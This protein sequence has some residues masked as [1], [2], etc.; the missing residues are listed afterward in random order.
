MSGKSGAGSGNGYQQIMSAFAA[1]AKAAENL[2]FSPAP[3]GQRC[4]HPNPQHCPHPESETQNDFG[5]PLGEPMSI[6]EVA[7][8]FGC[9]EW[10]IRQRYLPLGLPHF[11]LS[12]A[13]KLLFFHNQ[14]VRWVLEIQRQK[15]GII[16]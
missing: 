15:G 2:V 10:T 6:R 8:V 11:R 13:G 12:P 14:I 3:L 7:K 4:P 16:R 9:S 1:N 5:D